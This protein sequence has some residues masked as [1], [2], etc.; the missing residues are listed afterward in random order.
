MWLNLQWIQMRVE[1]YDLLHENLNFLLRFVL[2]NGSIHCVGRILTLTLMN[3][4]SFLSKRW[5]T[6]A[7]QSVLILFISHEITYHLWLYLENYANSRPKTCNE[8]MPISFD[9][10]SFQWVA[11]ALILEENCFACHLAF[12]PLCGHIWLSSALIYVY[13]WT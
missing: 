4:L 13:R 1:K 2:R 6:F 5:G 11:I 3:S 12:I 8:S 10:R 9:L 7:H